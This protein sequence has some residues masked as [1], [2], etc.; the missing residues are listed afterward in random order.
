MPELGHDHDSARYV[1]LAADYARQIRTGVLPP[2][3]QLPSYAEIA[4]KYNVSEIVVRKALDVLKSQGLVRSVPRRG[5][6]VADRPNL[7][8]ISPERQLEDPEETFGHESN[9]EV[10][11]DRSLSQ[12]PASD[13]VAEAFGIGAGEPVTW[14]V[15]RASEG[16]RPI[17]ISDS[18]QPIGVVGT[19]GAAI[20]E[21]TVADRLPAPSH[22]E[23][24]QVPPGNV[25]KTVHQRYITP[26][27]RVIMLSDVSYPRDRYDAF[28]FRMVLDPDED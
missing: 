4:R 2:T 3:M 8:R 27:G 16:D 15:V 21:E 1:S 24:L 20:L 5:I 13:D 14:T 6:F 17:S 11:I 9:Q 19:S 7:V 28:V 22:A 23:W 25:V 26:D 18:Y 12:V 10:R